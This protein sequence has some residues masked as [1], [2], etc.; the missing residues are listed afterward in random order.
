[1]ADG[2]SQEIRRTGQIAVVGSIPT[3]SLVL[4]T[5]GGQIAL[6][7]ERTDELRQLTGAQV[8][9]TGS[10]T[11][12]RIH[13]SGYEVLTVDGSPVISGDVEEARDGSLLLRTPAG[14]LYQLHDAPSSVRPGQTVWLQGPASLRIQRYGVIREP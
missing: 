1:M 6:E 3:E 4:R 10:G 13:V 9:V 8:T 11:A 5:D 7:G 14:Q 12:E 2:N